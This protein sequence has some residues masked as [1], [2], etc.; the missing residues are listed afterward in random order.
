MSSFYAN[1]IFWLN[2]NIFTFIRF[3]LQAKRPVASHISSQPR[4]SDRRLRFSVSCLMTW[5]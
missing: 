5:Q 4:S 2:T 1:A 3:W